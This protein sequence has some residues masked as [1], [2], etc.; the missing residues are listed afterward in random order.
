[1]KHN[2]NFSRL[3]KAKDEPTEP[4]QAGDYVRIKM[5][6]LHSVDMSPKTLFDIGFPNEFFVLATFDIKGERCLALEECCERR[7]N[8][9]TGQIL[10]NGHPEKYFEKT[11]PIEHRKTSERRFIA[12]EAF[13][14]KASVEY[15]SGQKKLLLKTP[16]T[17]E[18]ISLSG[19]VAKDI[20]DAARAVGLF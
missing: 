16:W 12:L 11:E 20:S 18:G 1:M 14:M 19:D 7:K 10:C 8:R 9:A 2:G 13:G 5:S 3:E 15:L 6:D 17:P 4:I